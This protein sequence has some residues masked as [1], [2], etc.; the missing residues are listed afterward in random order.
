MAKKRKTASNQRSVNR[1]PKTSTRS[2][3]SKK[4]TGRKVAG[5]TVS[6]AKKRPV[7]KRRVAK[8]AT[9]NDSLVRLQK[10]LAE[11]GVGSRR[12]CE[13]LIVEGRVEVDDRMVT[14][15]GE[16]VDPEKN[17]VRVDGEK[18]RI[19]KKRYFIINKPPGVVSTSKDPSGRVRVVDLISSHQR[20]YNVGRLDKSSQGLMLVT[21]DGTLAQRL[22]HPSFGVTKTYHVQVKGS[23]HSNDLEV[24]K[25][26]VHLAEGVAK[27]KEVRV[28]R[29]Q[30]NSTDLELVLDEGKNRE[31]RRLLARLGHKVVKLTRVA[32]GPLQMGDLKQGA[33]RKLT[34]EEVEGLKRS[35]ELGTGRKSRKG[36]EKAKPIGFDDF[37]KEKEE[38]I[39][40][41][42]ERKRKLAG[43]KP[44]QKKDEKSP[45]SP[46]GRRPQVRKSVGTAG[47]RDERGK[48]GFPARKGS[49]RSSIPR[50]GSRK[51]IGRPSRAKRM[52]AEGGGASGSGP[53]RTGSRTGKPS[54]SKK[55]TNRAPKGR[56]R[57]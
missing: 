25:R 45:D 5:R 46:R 18:V 40:E 17:V 51:G 2:R 27:V 35:V 12:D 42:G 9:E 26:G 43:K 37:Q 15:L 44:V 54:G 41:W 31:I 49:R 56:G 38:R 16:K 57:R 30:K 1:K 36:G 14:K 4:S 13:L 28:R 21:N 53:G 8:K 23:P 3:P 48:G 22:T 6:A 10:F 50:P 7:T 19:E 47:E 32:I 24:L 20:V 11:A 34:D 55:R 33:H 29:R 39:A 52:A